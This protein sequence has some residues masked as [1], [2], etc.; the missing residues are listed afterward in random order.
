MEI[1]YNASG[2]DKKTLVKAV[3]DII[4]EP[5]KYLGAPTF[6]YAVGDRYKIT[7]DGNLEVV[8]CEEH[9][10]VEHLMEELYKRGFT[11]ENMPEDDEEEAIGFSIG[12]PIAELSDKP[13]DDKIIENLNA[14]IAS[15]KALFQK[16]LDTEK[17]LSI[18]WEQDTLWFDWF[19]HRIDID[20]LEIY[21][22]FIKAL[23]KMA[24]NAVR[25]TA[26]EKPVENEKF[27]MRTFLNRIG[28]SGKEYK[29][30][31]KALIKNLSGNSAFR[32]GRPE[33]N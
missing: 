22:P 11:A 33:N 13:C 8:D 26:K 7:R 19:D 14:I 30:L 2:S 9:E 25:V 18:E 1:K 31:R 20:D 3:S 5:S 21:S 17:E 12:M 16:A 32:Y 24:E 4:G 23:Y 6:A 29:P 15:K 28:L 27:A 10:D